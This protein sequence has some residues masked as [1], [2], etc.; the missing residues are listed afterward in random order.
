[1]RPAGKRGTRFFSTLPPHQASESWPLWRGGEIIGEATVNGDRA[2]V[3]TE[4]DLLGKVYPTGRF[5]R[6]LG[7]S[8]PVKGPLPSAAK[9][10]LTLSG[11]QWK[12]DDFQADSMVTVAVAIQYLERLRDRT[13]RDDVK[14][15]V[16]R[17][18]AELT[19]LRNGAK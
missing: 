2:E 7:G 18:I 8:P 13:D 9:Y 14:K 6:S 10:R 5:S 11:A 4:F 17:S 3:W 19:A 12:I 16:G 15:N 1:V